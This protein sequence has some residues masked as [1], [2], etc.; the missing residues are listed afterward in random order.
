M[1]FYVIYQINILKALEQSNEKIFKEI[2]F[3]C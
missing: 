1:A 2:D 3:I